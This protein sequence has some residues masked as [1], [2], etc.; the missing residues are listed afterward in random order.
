APTSEVPDPEA[1]AIEQATAAPARVPQAAPPVTEISAQE[2]PAQ[3]EIIEAQAVQ[4]DEIETAL[5]PEAVALPQTIATPQ[6]RPPVRVAKPDPKPAAKP[7]PKPAP[8]TAQK[9]PP[10]SAT[11][12]D[13]RTT[14]SRASN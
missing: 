4:P 13:T 9:P 6:P 5:E 11:G 12:T 3:R 7:A 14:P 1:E 8:Q 10:H 2:T